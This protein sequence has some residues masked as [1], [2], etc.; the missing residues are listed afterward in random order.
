LNG[1][2]K[3]TGFS[4]YMKPSKIAG[5]LAPEAC[6][7]PRFSHS[8]S[9][10]LGLPLIPKDLQAIFVAYFCTGTCQHIHMFSIPARFSIVRPA[11]TSPLPPG[12]SKPCEEVNP[13]LNTS[14][15]NPCQ[16][17]IHR[18][19]AT[20]KSA[21]RP[22]PSRIMHFSNRLH[23]PQPL[24]TSPRTPARRFPFLTLTHP[25]GRNGISLLQR[26][27]LA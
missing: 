19:T 5:A 3:G 18:R 25:P 7:L 21:T 16:A 2:G 17:P 6:F 12:R 15:H 14:L 23:T 26:F 24:C 10:L 27:P 4:P 1:T 8:S 9:G 13:A 20:A 11:R 22:N